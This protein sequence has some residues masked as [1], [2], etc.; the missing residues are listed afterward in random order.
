MCVTSDNQKITIYLC[1]LKTVLQCFN[2]CKRG[3]DGEEEMQRRRTKLVGGE[4]WRLTG[5]PAGQK[6][7]FPHL[8]HLLFM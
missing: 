1:C 7:Y 2:K 4:E 8:P 5:R 3:F 6:V